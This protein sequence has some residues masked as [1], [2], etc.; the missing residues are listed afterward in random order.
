MPSI[1]VLSEPNKDHSWANPDIDGAS[2]S[3]Q[4]HAVWC[5]QSRLETSEIPI[6][7]TTGC[8]SQEFPS[9]L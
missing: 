7:Q 3:E 5:Q 8:P 9:P 1:R 6:E 2:E 4:R